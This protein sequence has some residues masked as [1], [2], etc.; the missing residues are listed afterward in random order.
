MTTSDSSL[1][2]VS[3]VVPIFHK[4]DSFWICMRRTTGVRFLELLLLQS[5]YHL[6]VPWFLCCSV[7][8]SARNE[9][10]LNWYKRTYPATWRLPL[11][12]LWSLEPSFLN[13]LNTQAS[14]VTASWH[15]S[16]H[17]ASN[18]I[19]FHTNHTMVV[20][21]DTRSWPKWAQNTCNVRP[22]RH[23]VF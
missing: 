7:I 16:N 5:C 18:F 23:W 21:R 19:A 12:G 6:Q 10:L 13:S 11:L 9:L 3:V 22:K 1:Y 2:L 17:F 20:G 4:K 14:L 15:Q 8:M